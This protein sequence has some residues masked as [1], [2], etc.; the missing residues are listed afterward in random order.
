MAAPPK[1]EDNV[2]Q[3]RRMLTT[4]QIVKQ[5]E[6][7]LSGMERWVSPEKLIRVAL[8]AINDDYKLMQ[9]TPISVV[10]SVIQLGQVGLVPDGF[11]GQAYLVP[12]KNKSLGAYEANPIIGYRGYGE[13]AVRSGK[14]NSVDAHVV[15]AG[16]VFDY[17]YGATPFLKH[18]P[19]MDPKKRGDPIAAYAI[20]YMVNGPHRFEVMPLDAI[21]KIQAESQGAG[22][23]DSP[24]KK[25]WEEMARKTPMRKLAKWVP[26]SPEFQMAAGID[27]IS[28]L[29]KRKT[30][31]RDDGQVAVVIEG[32]A[33][34][35]D[36]PIERP[37]S[38][39]TET[40]AQTITTTTEVK[41]AT[42]AVETPKP[43]ETTVLPPTTPGAA[44]CFCTCCKGG[45]CDCH[46]KEDIDQCGC[47][48]CQTTVKAVKAG[49]VEVPSSA[50]SS[51]APEPSPAPS[52][53][54]VEFTTP[55]K[56]KKLF[57]I[58][59][60]VWGKDLYEAKMHEFI[61]AKYG[62]KSAKEIPVT[63]FEKVCEEIGDALKVKQ[64]K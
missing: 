29:G 46:S 37:A 56:L 12:F 4:P 15:Y 9:C 16:D 48:P 47:I 59:K 5:V 45:K 21:M 17:E 44:K 33:T 51:P 26:L 34:E 60:S 49:H 30:V 14:A 7:A 1:P 3:I 35:V 24:W 28:D 61:L 25:H 57:A 27:E 11:L 8:T 2:L 58:A 54:A 32:V 6:S 36:A 38:V 31:M 19:Q 18:K 23:D 63:I 50:P 64:V 62:I 20:V 39:S 55:L 41:V 13:L 52:A 43:A 53:P 22:S 40:T 42:P 10:G